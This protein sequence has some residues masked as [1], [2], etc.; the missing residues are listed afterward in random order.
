MYAND[1]KVER[2]QS[3]AQ[4]HASGYASASPFPHAAFDDFVPAEWCDRLLE[5]FPDFGGTNALRYDRKVCRNK[6][7]TRGDGQFGLH[8]REVMRH[9]TGAAF[10]Q[11]L[12]TL[13]GIKGLIP[14]PYYEGGGLHEI[15]RG[16]HLKVHADFNWHKRLCL[17][18][19]IN[20]ILYLN[21][22]WQEDY[23]GHLELW[24]RDMKQC[25][26]KVLPVINRCVIFS[27]TSWSYHGH[28]GMLNCPPDRTRKS[29]AL[30][31]YTNG[32]PEEEQSEKH[33][34]LWRDVPSRSRFGRLARATLHATANVAEVPA[35]VMRS[36]ARRVG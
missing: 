25:V 11:F 31:Y 23:G 4:Q 15:Q 14:D 24:D 12:E 34:T 2:W 22:D 5:E 32:R 21:K 36:L 10:L 27:T 29:L 33:G 18:R 13:T 26:R 30:Y 7:A 16:G 8:T 19:R 6:T 9:L 17:D 3:L 28:P 20:L 35:R 1:G